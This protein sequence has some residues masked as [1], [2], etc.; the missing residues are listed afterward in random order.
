MPVFKKDFSIFNT[1]KKTL[2]PHPSLQQSSQPSPPPQ[3]QLPVPSAVQRGIVHHSSLLLLQRNGMAQEPKG[4]WDD[5]EIY[6]TPPRRA[7]GQRPFFDPE[8]PARRFE[9]RQIR[10]TIARREAREARINDEAYLQGP[11]HRVAVSQEDIEDVCCQLREAGRWENM[12]LDMRER[13]REMSRSSWFGKETGDE[14]KCRLTAER[15]MKSV[16]GPEYVSLLLN[17]VWLRGADG[18]LAGQRNMNPRRQRSL[19]PRQPRSDPRGGCQTHRIIHTRRCRIKIRTG[20]RYSRRRRPK[21]RRD[22]PS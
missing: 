5:K 18:I 16:V 13:R 7:P 11:A 3:L 14:R 1:K 17:L 19:S 6:E 2:P 8:S 22:P 9:S 20:T 21:A 15:A 12:H 10:A 4:L